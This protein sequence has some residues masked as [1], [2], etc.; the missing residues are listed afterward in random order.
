MLTISDISKETGISKKV[1]WSEIQNGRLTSTKI[2]LKYYIKK[3][4]WENFF[5]K[6][7]FKA[8][9]QE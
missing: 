6:R 2:G 1:I 5:N 7:T 8:Q 3:N 9:K 4:D